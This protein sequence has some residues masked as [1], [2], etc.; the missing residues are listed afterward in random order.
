[1][2]YKM[3]GKFPS[4]P[5]YGRYFDAHGACPSTETDARAEDDEDY[6]Y[7]KQDE[8]G[9]FIDPEGQARAMDGRV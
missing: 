4:L 5:Q 1:M 6:S 3:G 9:F 7:L 2:A 8:F